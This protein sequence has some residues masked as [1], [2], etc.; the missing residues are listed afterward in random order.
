[1]AI[2]FTYVLKQIVWAITRLVL[3]IIRVQRVNWKFYGIYMHFFPV[4]SC[5]VNLDTL[6]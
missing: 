4:G 5:A 6:F 2:L 3:E 1:M